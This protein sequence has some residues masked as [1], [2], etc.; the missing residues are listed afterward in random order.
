M[1]GLNRL[2]HKTKYKTKE[3]EKDFQNDGSSGRI[4][5]I[6]GFVLR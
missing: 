1:R 3:Y 2:D 5:H 6:G 4:V